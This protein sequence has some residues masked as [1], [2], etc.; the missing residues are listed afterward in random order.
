MK[1]K[2][3]ETD[4][5]TV[6]PVLSSFHRPR[7]VESKNADPE[8]QFLLKKNSESNLLMTT[9]KERLTRRFNIKAT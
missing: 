4:L 1:I 5:Q 2:L 9:T 8:R 6:Q 3:L 7:M